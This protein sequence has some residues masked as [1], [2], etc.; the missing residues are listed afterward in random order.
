MCCLDRRAGCICRGL[1]RPTRVSRHEQRAGRALQGGW[2]EPEGCRKHSQATNL[3]QA[4]GG[5]QGFLLPERYYLVTLTR[6]ECFVLE[7]I[8]HEAFG[9]FKACL[10]LGALAVA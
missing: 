6:V 8:G 2:P 3:K 10:P 5:S 1:A 7:F 4:G 9:V